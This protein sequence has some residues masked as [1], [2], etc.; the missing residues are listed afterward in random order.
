MSKAESDGQHLARLLETELQGKVALRRVSYSD[1]ELADP[2]AKGRLV[3][4]LESAKLVV[5]LGDESSRLVLGEVENARVYF[6]AASASGQ[7]LRGGSVSCLFTYSAEDLL[8][9]LPEKAKRGV[10]VL[11]TPGYEPLLPEIKA[12]AAKA[13]AQVT[14]K[15]VAGRRQLPDAVRDTEDMTKAIWVLG[16]PILD[17]GAS[18]EFL[19]ERA[20]ALGL[21]LM[22]A[23]AGRVARGAALASVAAP[24][25][26]TR[27]AAQAIAALAAGGKAGGLA[28]APAGG[29]IIY[30]AALK[31]RLGLSPRAPQWQ[32]AQ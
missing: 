27:R 15:S 3:A 7:T 32:K 14:A 13:G 21:P 29:P 8:R 9:A 6:V 31:D 30:N 4:S 5:A 19:T 23:A 26:L 24:E 22:T 20:L 1:R 10:L 2:I 17:E 28:L 25:S 11:Y 18:F 12:A 16:D